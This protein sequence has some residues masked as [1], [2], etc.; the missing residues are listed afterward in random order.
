MKENFLAPLT[1][2]I[3]QQDTAKKAK[4][5]RKLAIPPITHDGYINNLFTHIYNLYDVYQKPFLSILFV[6]VEHR[7]RPLHIVIIA[8]PKYNQSVH[9][10]CADPTYGFNM[11]V[12]FLSSEG[13]LF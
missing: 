13:K 6:F 5:L 9:R 11:I 1:L 4:G 8:N 2:R 10:S 7:P 12:I 3:V